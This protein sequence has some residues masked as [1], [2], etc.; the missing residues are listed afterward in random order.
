MKKKQKPRTGGKPPSSPTQ[1]FSTAICRW[2]PVALLGTHPGTGAA[3]P[4]RHPLRDGSRGSLSPKNRTALPPWTP[5][6]A[7]LWLSMTPLGAALPPSGTWPQ[8]HISA[9]QRRAGCSEAEAQSQP[10]FHGAEAEGRG[11]KPKSEQT[12]PERC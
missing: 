7:L 12:E 1:A 5:S 11:G 2:V 4:A 3:V 6:N 9:G 8:P 10:G